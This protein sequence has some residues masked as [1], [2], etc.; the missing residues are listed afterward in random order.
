MDR[1][2]KEQ[3]KKDRTK[4]ELNIRNPQYRNPDTADFLLYRISVYFDTLIVTGN[5]EEFPV[6]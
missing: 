5:H 6:T 1:V 4:I 2:Q 3:I